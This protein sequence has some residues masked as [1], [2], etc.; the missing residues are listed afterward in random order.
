LCLYVAALA[1]A[2][3]QVLAGSRGEILKLGTMALAFVFFWITRDE[4]LENRYQDYRAL[5]EGFRVQAVWTR[6][7]LQT[8]EVER[9]YLR[10]QQSELQWIRLALRYASLAERE[11]PTG[12]FSVDDP[13]CQEWIRSQWRYYYRAARREA[14][15]LGALNLAVKITFAVAITAAVLGSIALF[16]AHIARMLTF[17][18]MGALSAWSDAGNHH[19]ILE[20]IATAP[21]ALA[22]VIAI[23]VENYC[24]KRGYA[25]NVKRY[26][27]MFIVFDRARRQLRLVQAKRTPGDPVQIV[28]DLSAAALVE[29]ADWLLK[30]RERPWSFVGT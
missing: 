15:E 16:S 3:M 26:E 8:E 7:G 19:A 14:R 9:S 29:H 30:R 27:R 21:L 18:P 12:S 2:A 5:S 23:L 1:A 28:R 11:A 24:S 25:S 17:M 20:A 6:I 22:T 10:M 4:D 13:A